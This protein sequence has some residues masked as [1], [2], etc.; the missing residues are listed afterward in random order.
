MRG[1]AK[2]RKIKK[3]WTVYCSEFEAI[4]KIVGFIP[5]VF[6][7]SSIVLSI[8]RLLVASFSFVEY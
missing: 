6:M 8:V 4:N 3:S 5:K 2:K 1:L 7:V